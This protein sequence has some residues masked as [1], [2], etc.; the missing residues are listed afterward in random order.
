MAY[1]DIIDPTGND[2][3]YL[4]P[5]DGSAILIGA[6]AHFFTCDFFFSVL[7]KFCFD[8]TGHKSTDGNTERL[9]F[10]LKRKSKGV[11]CGLR[12]GIEGLERNGKGSS[13][14]AYVDYSSAFLL[15]HKFK[16]FF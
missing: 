3:R 8:I 11:Y 9:Y 15:S 1:I 16:D 10:I 12:S 6:D 14:R 5:E 4:L 7:S 13:H 2:F